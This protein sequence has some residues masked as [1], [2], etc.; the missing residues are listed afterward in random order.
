KEYYMKNIESNLLNEDRLLSEII[1]QKDLH[2][3]SNQQ[4][5]EICKKVGKDTDTRVTV[6]NRNGKVLG[7]SEFDPAKL[8]PHND[9][10]E[11]YKALRGQTGVAIRYSQTARTN[12]IYVA[13][14][15]TSTSRSGVVRMSTPLIEAEK[16]YRHIWLVLLLTILAI[17]AMAVLISLGIADRIS[18]PLKD[19]TEAVKDIAR[20][21]LKRRITYNSKDELGILAKSFN[22]MAENLDNNIKEISGVKNRMEALLYNTVNG[23]IMIDAVFKITYANPAA[24]SLLGESNEIIGRKYVEVIKNYELLEMIDRVRKQL[25]SER[26]VIVMHSLGGK[27]VDINIVPI[28]SRSIDNQGFLVVLNDI[29]DM[30]RLEQVRKDFIANVSHELKTPVASISGFAET[31]M[32]EGGENPENVKEFSGIIYKQSQRLSRMINRLLELSRLESENRELNLESVNIN[33]LIQD[34]INFMQQKNDCLDKIISFKNT[35]DPMMINADPDI[36]SQVLINL[37]DNAVKYGSDSDHIIVGV[38]KLNNE[39][40][41]S[42]E[43]HGIGIPDNEKDRVF[44]RFYRVDKT[45][46]RKTGGTGLGLAIAKHLVENHGGKIGVDNIDGK[47]IFSFTVPIKN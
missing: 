5:E 29:T 47:T 20:G 1:K 28:I 24:I 22:D 36:I 37:L 8:G 19:M 31:L 4:I 42:V 35:N 7:D 46:S 33:Q 45:R 38:E 2:N 21:N 34:T 17:G 16:L 27:I 15:F 13:I 12:M 25:Q 18:R 41:I 43:D 3:I 40:K 23:I 9:R 6:I 10:P 30:K 39:V 14:P 26:R 44:E 11:V 32:E